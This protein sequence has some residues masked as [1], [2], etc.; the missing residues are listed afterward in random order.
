MYASSHSCTLCES[1]KPV[2]VDDWSIGAKVLLWEGG[3]RGVAFVRGTNSALAP[4][5]AGG[6]TSA[7]MHATDWL[8]TL[9]RGLAGASTENKTLPLDGEDQWGVLARGEATRRTA[10]FHN[11][12]VGS[13]P[14]AFTDP[15][16]NRTAYSTSACLSHVDDRV[17]GGCHPFGA[18]GGAIRRGDIKL[19]TTF[20]GAH[21][22]EDSAP[23]GTPQY[24][25]GG[26]FANGTR[27]FVPV[28]NDSVPLLF[29]INAT[30]GVFLF[31]IT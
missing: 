31:N 15:S 3:I 24:P 1:K 16:T 6:H 25:P 13:A 11:V 17:G 30:L 29:T 27:V 28:T 8:P 26:R 5:P 10:I 21:P 19:L 2:R 20:P 4:V 9:C 23:A 22:W 7:L 18:T 12:P 14:V